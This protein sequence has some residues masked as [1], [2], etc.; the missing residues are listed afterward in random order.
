MVF[1]P[2]YATDRQVC[3]AVLLAIQTHPLIQNPPVYNPATPVGTQPEQIFIRKFRT[4]AGLELPEQGLTL[5]VFPTGGFSNK[6]SASIEFNTYT[7]GRPEPGEYQDRSRFRLTIEA[8]ITESSF[9]VPLQVQYYIAPAQDMPHGYAVQHVETSTQDVSLDPNNSVEAYIVPAEEIL[10]DYMTLIRSVIRDQYIFQPYKIRNPSILYTNYLTSN[11]ISQQEAQN[12]IFHRA[13]TVVEFDIFE[14]NIARDESNLYFVEWIKALDRYD[15]PT[16]AINDLD[17]Y[18]TV[19][20]PNF[21]EHNS[22][23]FVQISL[24]ADDA[25][26][27]AIH[28][29]TAAVIINATFS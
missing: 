25:V 6:T 3:M 9:D 27:I 26:I 23:S 17:N 7:L 5:S 22:H 20:Q 11:T 15:N 28:P 29:S 1:Q 8:T 19:L 14:F 12:L 24:K 21:V 4:Y 18:K 16:T 10:R 13:H 2:Y